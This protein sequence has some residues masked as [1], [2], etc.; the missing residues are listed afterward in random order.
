MTTTAGNILTPTESLHARIPQET[1]EALDRI[2]D[3]IGRSRNWVFNEA[4]KQYVDI[5][6]WQLELIKER[7]RDAEQKDAKFI[8]HDAIIK[9]YEKRLKKKLSI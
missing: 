9:R 5:H 3:S 6:Q 8:S 2:A 7:L 1:I 4:L